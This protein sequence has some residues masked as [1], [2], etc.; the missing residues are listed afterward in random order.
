[1]RIK[2]KGPTRLHPFGFYLSEQFFSAPRVPVA[3]G[4]LCPG[5]QSSWEQ[6]GMEAKAEV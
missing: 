1:V 6:V 5:L 4:Q 3:V 2:W